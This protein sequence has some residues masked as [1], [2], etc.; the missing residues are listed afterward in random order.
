MYRHWASD[1]Q[2]DI[3]F[4]GAI[5]GPQ[6]LPTIL[7]GFLRS[8]KQSRTR[9]SALVMDMS[10]RQQSVSPHNCQRIGTTPVEAST[11]I[12]VQSNRSVTPSF[13]RSGRCRR[14]SK[15]GKKSSTTTEAWVRQAMDS[16]HAV[17]HDVRCISPSGLTNHHTVPVPRSLPWPYISPSTQVA[18]AQQQNAGGQYR[19]RSVAYFSRL[20]T[21]RGRIGDMNAGYSHAENTAGFH[22]N[23]AK[24]SEFHCNSLRQAAFHIHATP[25]L[26]YEQGAF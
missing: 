14:L 7:L 15:D 11:S 19:A 10:V 20:P 12:M 3:S 2:P 1:Q 23:S 26:D 16:H 25:C 17:P 8:I 5:S 9:A 4:L 21:L 6:P 24:S 18:I 22:L 13:L